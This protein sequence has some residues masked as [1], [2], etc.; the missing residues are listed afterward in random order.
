MHSY[1]WRGDTLRGSASLY[2][3]CHPAVKW[4]NMDRHTWLWCSAQ[5]F[6][7]FPCC[8]APQH[9]SR[10]LFSLSCYSI[11]CHW[12]IHVTNYF[13]HFRNLFNDSQHF[14]YDR[15]LNICEIDNLQKN[16][17]KTTQLTFYNEVCIH[18][19]THKYAS[20][21]WIAQGLTANKRL[22]IS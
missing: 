12:L 17:N 10:L 18:A 22:L 8:P 2:Q 9:P 11:A 13:S 19:N 1:F 14:L 5:S 15:Y 6:R 20:P 21:W 7:R 3:I 4:V 16:C